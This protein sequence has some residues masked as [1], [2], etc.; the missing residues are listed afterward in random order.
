MMSSETTQVVHIPEHQ[1]SSLSF[2]YKSFYIV[3]LF[4]LQETMGFH[5]PGIRT[6][7]ASFTADQAA[8][9][10]V[11]VPKGCLA[12]YVGEEMKR[13]IIPIS[14]LN[15]PSFQELLGQA[16]EE[17]GY[18]HP[19]GGLT[20]RCREDVFIEVTSQLNGQ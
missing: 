18:D 16:E 20:I 11:E 1:K 6:R 15:Q 5:L 14:Y 17:F 19:M 10:S 7:R 12:V 4:F 2:S 3:S 9:K 13:I 8:S